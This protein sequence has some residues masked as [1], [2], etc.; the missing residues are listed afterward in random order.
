[1]TWEGFEPHARRKCA[2]TEKAQRDVTQKPNTLPTRLSRRLIKA[3]VL[4][5]CI[6][7]CWGYTAPFS[8]H[9]PIGPK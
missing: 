3:G 7:T 2:L 1:M 4:V 9:C 8:T 5:V 6:R